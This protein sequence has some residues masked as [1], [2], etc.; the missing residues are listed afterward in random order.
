MPAMTTV[1]ADTKSGLRTPG[2]VKL[3]N[4]AD[5]ETCPRNMP[6]IH[7]SP[8]AAVTTVVADTKSGL[9]TPVVVTVWNQA[10][11][12]TC[13][14]SVPPVHDPQARASS[15]GFMALKT[16]IAEFTENYYEPKLARAVAQEEKSCI[17]HAT[18][19]SGRASE[20]IIEEIMIEFGKRHNQVTFKGEI[21]E[22]PRQS[23]TAEYMA[24]LYALRKLKDFPEIL[25]E[26]HTDHESLSM[27]F[28]ICTTSSDAQFA[29]MSKENGL[30]LLSV[31]RTLERQRKYPT[32]VKWV[33]SHSGIFGN[34]VADNL[35]GKYTPQGTTIPVSEQFKCPDNISQHA[36]RPLTFY[37]KHLSQMPVR[38]LIKTINQT[39]RKIDGKDK[40][41]PAKSHDIN[42]KLTFALLNKGT[43]PSTFKTGKQESSTKA[44]NVKAMANVLPTQ[45][46]LSEWYKGVYPNGLCRLCHEHTEDNTHVW[47]CQSDYAIGQRFLI[48]QNAVSLF[49]EA[50]ISPA[51]SHPREKLL[52][53]ALNH[54]PC[55]QTLPSKLQN[56]FQ[57]MPATFTTEQRTEIISRLNAITFE[58]LAKGI[59]PQALLECIQ[60]LNKAINITTFEKI[61]SNARI[62]LQILQTCDTIQRDCRE[63]WNQRCA[64]TI[65]WEQ[66]HGITQDQKRKHAATGEETLV[67]KQ[68]EKPKRTRAVTLINKEAK[69]QKTELAVKLT[70]DILER[71]ADNSFINPGKNLIKYKEQKADRSIPTP[72]TQIERLEAIYTT[73]ATPMFRQT[74]LIIDPILTDKVEFSDDDDYDLPGVKTDEKYEPN[75]FRREGGMER[76]EEEENII[77]R[78]GH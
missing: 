6:S 41:M 56:V 31:I 57:Y 3:H 8:M 40:L 73:T 71:K 35:A 54:I 36:V 19:I 75:I 13:P 55:L 37:N 48:K 20:K 46:R 44:Y 16:D 14:R 22:G 10:D 63:Y 49:I 23:W 58:D 53:R 18:D 7:T 9:R 47:N 12:E 67:I 69:R 5:V 76:P 59:M 1:M 42:W 61:G 64:I 72:E 51:K 25:L 11:A 21:I 62:T 4:Q 70:K 77:C 38:Q 34:A 28:I 45:H 68:S 26:L 33:K 30:P 17:D 52:W 50:I 65:K 24:L 74:R 32:Q 39:N 2:V 43:K 29:N 78:L 15:G 60:E 66:D 27:L